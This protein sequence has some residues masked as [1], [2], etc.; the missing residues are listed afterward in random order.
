MDEVELATNFYQK[1]IVEWND[2]DKPHLNNKTIYQLFEEQ[3]ARTPARI[4][5]VYEEH[6]LTY[7]ELDQQANHVAHLI[8]TYYHQKYNQELRPDT[9]IALSLQRSHFMI[10]GILGILKAGAAYVPVDSNDPGERIGYILADIGCELLLST[11]DLINKLK[12]IT[13]A[14]TNI[15]VLDE[16][17]V[18]NDTP[19]L[20]NSTLD[21]L[22]YIIYTSGT[23]GAPKGVMISH[24][25][26][27]ESPHF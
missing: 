21:N 27:H 7:K 2:T 23:T 5:L 18:C 8:R 13:P 19:L 14:T 3:A 6:Q 12:L 20:I 9:L 17:I 26:P 11:R 10:I 15:L 16:Q 22:A 25:N 1:T 4:A 24:A